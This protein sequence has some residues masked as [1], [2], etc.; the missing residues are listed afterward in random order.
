MTWFG[1]MLVTP[2]EGKRVGVAEVQGRSRRG[3]RRSRSMRGGA[4]SGGERGGGGYIGASIW[5]GGFYSLVM[6]TQD[7]LPDLS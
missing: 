2:Q 1:S 5:P 4:V 7:T 6:D 3:S